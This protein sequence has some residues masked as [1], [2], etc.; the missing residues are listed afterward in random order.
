[1]IVFPKEKPVMANLNSYYLNIEKLVEHY[2]GEIGSGAVF[3]RAATATA[4]IFFDPDSV[5]NVYFQNKKDFF[6]DS[7][8]Q[9]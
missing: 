7:L 4:V 3:G 6:Q 1:M 8:K 2:Q 5:V 9:G